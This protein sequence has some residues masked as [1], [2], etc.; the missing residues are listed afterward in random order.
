M[1]L[2]AT[3]ALS[4]D[5]NIAGVGH[6]TAEAINQLLEVHQFLIDEV[7][8]LDVFHRVDFVLVH[9]FG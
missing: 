8:V 4:I 7:D 5:L 3:L 1:H 9:A 6:L 2:I